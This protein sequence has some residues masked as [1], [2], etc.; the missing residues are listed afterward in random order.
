MTIPKLS[1]TKT[2]FL[3]SSNAVL[4]KHLVDVRRICNKAL[5]KPSASRT[6]KNRFSRPSA[7]II[8]KDLKILFKTHMKSKKNI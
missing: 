8:A 6:K 7:S 3:V 1:N 2:A 5:S 4:K